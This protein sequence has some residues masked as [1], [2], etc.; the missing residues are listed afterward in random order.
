M[1]SASLA[2]DH[3]AC[4]AFVGHDQHL[5]QRRNVEARVRGGHQERRVDIRSEDMLSAATAGHLAAELGA[6]RKDG[7]NH[8][9]LLVGNEFY[10]DPIPDLGKS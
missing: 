3:R 4:A 1:A 10:G 9:L 5:L 8:R 2:K 7:L 6:S